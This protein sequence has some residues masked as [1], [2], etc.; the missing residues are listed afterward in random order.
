MRKP[1]WQIR[2]HDL[3]LAER[4][5]PFAW[6]THDCILFAKRTIEAVSDIQIVLPGEW[7]DELEAEAITEAGGGL[8][9]L[10]SLYLGS[11][12]PWG[13]CAAGDVV[14][15]RLDADGKNLTLAVHDGAQ[16]VAPGPSGLRR[17]PFMLALKGWR[18]Q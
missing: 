15:M 4:F 10:I 16:L 7:H 2:L 11:S 6:G 1:D 8:E 3:L 5:T 18:V 14:L 12:V 17:V 9:N 13:W